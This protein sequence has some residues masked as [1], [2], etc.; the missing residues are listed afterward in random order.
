MLKPLSQQETCGLCGGKRYIGLCPACC[1]SGVVRY[2]RC[3]GLGGVPYSAGYVWLLGQLPGLVFCGNVPCGS[4]TSA[5][6][7]FDWGGQA[8][9]ASVST[10]GPERY[11]LVA[12]CSGLTEEA[13][14]R[15]IAQEDDNEG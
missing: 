7:V 15:W 8:L 9:L 10:L 14:A 2:W 5:Q 13:I 3:V 4:D 1:G 12:Y 11:E 6:F